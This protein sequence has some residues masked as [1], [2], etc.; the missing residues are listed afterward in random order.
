MN[1]KYLYTAFVSCAI[2]LN[3][4]SVQAEENPN[5]KSPETAFVCATRGGTPTMFAYTP[6]QINLEPL[7]SWHAEYLLPEQSGPQVCQ[8]TAAK[9]QASYQQEEAQ[10]LKAETPKENNLVCLVTQEEEN[11]AAE[12]SQKLFS[13]NPDYEAGC[14]LDNM[15]PL[16]CKALRGRGN[17]Y[18]FDD[19]PYQTIW[20]PW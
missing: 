12:G 4:F 6:G 7:M 11:C 2:V 5:K 14:V 9:L 16:E 8:Q 15:K 20:W 18:S 13:V 17:I 3:A 19:K 1:K 10:Y